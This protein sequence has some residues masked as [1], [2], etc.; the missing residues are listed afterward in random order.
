[1]D[2]L[3]APVRRICALPAPHAFSPTLDEVLRPSVDRIVRD[4]AAL[5]K[6]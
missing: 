3:D 1:L 4:V 2:E 5:M 6:G